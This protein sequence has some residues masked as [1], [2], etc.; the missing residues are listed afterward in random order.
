[1][2]YF[3]QKMEQQLTDAIS[4]PEGWV[5]RNPE[6]AQ[7]FNDNA[8]HRNVHDEPGTKLHTPDWKWVA[9]IPTPLEDTNRIINSQF[10]QNKKTFYAWLKR[11]PSYAVYDAKFGR[12]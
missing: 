8:R 12:T 7:L 6:Y 3:V 10:L 2:A 11:N 9:R 1:M 5:E 4:R